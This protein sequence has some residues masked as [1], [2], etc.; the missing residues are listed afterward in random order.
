MAKGGMRYGA[1]RPG[2][3]RKAEASTAFDIR[4]IARKGYLRGNAWFTW[5]W[6]NS[7]SGE[8]VG[9]VSVRVSDDPERVVLSYQWTPYDSDPQ[10]VECTLRVN[11]TACTYGGNRPWFLCPQC[12]QRCAVVYFGA[13]G[14]RYA[15]RK[16]VRVAYCSQS[17]DVMAR[18]WR[19]QGKIEKR[20][21]GG[22][23]EWNGWQRPKGMHHK[24][25]HRL[26]DKIDASEQQKD[27]ALMTMME[28][29]GLMF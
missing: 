19:K 3:K 17:E 7:Y 23:G 16:C 1:G 21:A 9:R 26:L 18:A 13:R 22:E 25:F 24:T 28:R 8:V 20:L 27:F 11:R 6:T 2:W 10:S 5:V 4:H 29:M 12:G 14:G 15:C